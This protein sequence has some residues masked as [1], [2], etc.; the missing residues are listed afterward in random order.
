MSPSVVLSVKRW[1]TKS[2]THC[3]KSVQIFKRCRKTIEYSTIALWVSWVWVLTRGPFPILSPSGSVY[4]LSYHNKGKNTK[5][6]IYK[7]K[8]KKKNC[9]GPA[10]TTIVFLCASGGSSPPRHAFKSFN[11][12]LAFDYPLHI[13]LMSLHICKTLIYSNKWAAETNPEE[14][15]LLKLFLLSLHTKNILMASYY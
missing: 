5:I 8:K 4:S 6:I 15:K 13:N 14:K 11:A 3:W 7:V 1:I 9:S 2:Y 12:Q 10:R